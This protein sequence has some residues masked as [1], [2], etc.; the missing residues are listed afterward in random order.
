MA[1]FTPL[2]GSRAASTCR[3]QQVRGWKVTMSMSLST[4]SPMNIRPICTLSSC[5]RRQSTC[6]SASL[7]EW[8]SC[9]P[10]P[11]LPDPSAFHSSS[12]P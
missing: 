2:S 6:T 3:P 1:L 11:S 9:L 10:V 7:M 8:K 4:D 5:T 12:P